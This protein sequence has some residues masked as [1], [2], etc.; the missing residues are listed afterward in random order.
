MLG[1]ASA[2]LTLDRYGHLF[3]DELDAVAARLDESARQAGVY[4]MRTEADPMLFG[5]EVPDREK[6]V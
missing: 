5:E 4:R 1:H 3:P 2:T 6:A